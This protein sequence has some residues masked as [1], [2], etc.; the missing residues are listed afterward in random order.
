[1][2]YLKIKKTESDTL[3]AQRRAAKEALDGLISDHAP[4]LMPYEI[5]HTD[6]GRPYIKGADNI[7]IS[8][9]HTREYAACALSFNGNIGIDIEKTVKANMRV[10]KKYFREEEF[11]HISALSEEDAAN[12]F[13]ALWTKYEAKAKYLGGGFADMRKDADA[14]VHTFTF[15]GDDGNEY[16]LSVCTKEKEDIDFSACR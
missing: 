16:A 2:I 15:N 6:M 8:I 13:T 3:E 1:M 10:A 5:E 7:D 9:S 4:Q 12:A 14:Y 11:E